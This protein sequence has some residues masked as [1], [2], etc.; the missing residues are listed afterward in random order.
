MHDLDRA[1]TVGVEVRQSAVVRYGRSAVIALAL[2]LVAVDF[3]P[4][5]SYQSG[6]SIVRINAMSSPFVDYGGTEIGVVIVVAFLALLAWASHWRGVPWSAWGSVAV[7]AG[8]LGTLLPDLWTRNTISVLKGLGHQVLSV[9][10][11]YGFWLNLSLVL[12]ILLV[13]SF[14]LWNE[15]R[16]IR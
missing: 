4:N 10:L 6:G 5:G 7:V 1:S 9:K 12:T 15:P 3:L 16:L 11:Q 8:L 13:S 14:V 2:I